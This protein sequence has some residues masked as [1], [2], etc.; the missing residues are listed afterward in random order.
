MLEHYG[1]VCGE[2]RAYLEARGPVGELERTAM[3]VIDA[4]ARKFSVSGDLSA[5]DEEFIRRLGGVVAGSDADLDQRRVRAVEICERYAR[6]YSTETDAER[7]SV[8]AQWLGAELFSRTDRKWLAL[9]DDAIRVTSL[10]DRFTQQTKP[11]GGLGAIGLL[12]HL[13]APVG[14]LGM[15][16]W[17]RGGEPDAHYIEAR[18]AEI[19]GSSERARSRPARQ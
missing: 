5:D 8:F 17:G 7:R 12:A 3:S 16:A 14:A 9:K 1:R 15:P 4:L 10:L 6:A 2:F 18:K 11:G 13:N 19:R